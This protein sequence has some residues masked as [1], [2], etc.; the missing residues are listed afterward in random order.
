MCEYLENQD[1]L[2]IFNRVKLRIDNSL[3]KEILPFIE[4]ERIQDKYQCASNFVNYKLSNNIET[5][6]KLLVKI[7]DLKDDEELKCSFK[8]VEKF[9]ASSESDSEIMYNDPRIRNFYSTYQ[10]INEELNCIGDFLQRALS[11]MTYNSDL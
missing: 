10:E 9:V 1:P 11:L 4:N 7:E 8:F 6:N 3:S 2:E 5:I